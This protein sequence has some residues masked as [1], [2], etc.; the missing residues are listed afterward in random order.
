MPYRFRSPTFHI[1][2]IFFLVHFR[3]R[4]YSSSPGTGEVTYPKHSA[5]NKSALVGKK[6][7]LIDGFREQL[8]TPMEKEN[9]KEI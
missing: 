6:D 8:Y 2:G 7:A 4:S 5:S 3:C 9:W 1:P